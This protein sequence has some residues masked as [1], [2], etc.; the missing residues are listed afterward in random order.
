MR[1]LQEKIIAD[2]P[3]DVIE[4]VKRI[5]PSLDSLKILYQSHSGKGKKSLLNTFGTIGNWILQYI[6]DIRTLLSHTSTYREKKQH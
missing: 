5:H 6:T 1:F 4:K 3:V 2:L